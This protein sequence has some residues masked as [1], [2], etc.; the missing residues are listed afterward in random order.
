MPARVICL[1]CG[2]EG[3]WYKGLGTEWHHAP[4]QPVEVKDATGA[5][6]AF[7]AGFLTYWMRQQPLD[8]CV[9]NGIAT[10]AQRLEGKI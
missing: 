7:W 6:D 1:T 5:G 4:A 8:S 10:A 2:P 3:V 9:R